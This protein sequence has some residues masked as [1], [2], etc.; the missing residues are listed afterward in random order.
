MITDIHAHYMPLEYMELMQRIL[1]HA[2]EGMPV[3]GRSGGHPSSDSQEHIDGRLRLMDAAGVRKQVLSPAGRG[4]V[5]EKEADAVAAARLCNDS[6]AELARR[7]PE[8]IAAFVSL[9]LPHIDA[10]LKEMQR[11]LDELGMAGVTM[12]CFVLDRSTAEAE[13]EPL[14]EEMNR[15]HSV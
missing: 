11:G 10:S 2:P 6:F 5:A 13:F 14:Y 3:R 9:P 7:Y 15:R 1:G 12:N 4:P 8:R